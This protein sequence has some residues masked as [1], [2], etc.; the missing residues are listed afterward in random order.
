MKPQRIS[1]GATVRGSEHHRIAERRPMVGTIVNHY[2]QDG[3]MV[4]DVCF[5]DRLRW[6]L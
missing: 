1:L 6:L 4:V 2:G 5:S 3:Y